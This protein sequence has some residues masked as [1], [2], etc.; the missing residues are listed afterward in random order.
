MPEDLGLLIRKAKLKLFTKALI[1]FGMCANKFTWDI[2]TFDENI[3]G[4]VRFDS[5]NLNK[6]ESG[7]IFLNKHFLIRPDY[8]YNNL[9]FIICHEL[10]HILNKHGARRGD[11][12]WEEWNVACDHVV[13]VFLKKL[14]DTI[15]PYNNRYNIIEELEYHKSNC[16]A[17]YAYDWIMKHP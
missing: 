14:S 4:Y 11:R 10:L 6:I 9:I 3:E 8:T 2:E 16:T 15:K 17:E 12:K 1:F 5:E 13:E 7:A